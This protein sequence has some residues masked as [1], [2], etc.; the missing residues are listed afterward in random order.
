MSKIIDIYT[1]QAVMEHFLACVKII[2]N[3]L[4]SS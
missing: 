2:N 3:E 4:A 1:T